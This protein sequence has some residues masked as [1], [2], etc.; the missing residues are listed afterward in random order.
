MLEL[1]GLCKAYDRRVG[2]ALIP[3]YLERIENLNQD[4]ANPENTPKEEDFLKN[5]LDNIQRDLDF[6]EKQVKDDA[7]KIYD[8]WQEIVNLRKKN[9]DGYANTMYDLKVHKGDL[10]DDVLFQLKKKGT[11]DHP[12]PV[13]KRKANV[14]KTP[15]LCRLL[16]DG[17]VVAE[18][19]KVAI[20]WPSYEINILDQFSIH[21]FTLPGNVQL[22]IVINGKTIDVIELEIPGAHVKTLTSASRMVKEY[23]FS[24]I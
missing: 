15:A 2:L 21:M 17:K 23:G 13:L 9:P 12:D 16:I 5:M 14:Q 8:L 11:Q 19:R 18:T 20:D 24:S 1:K 22:E 6:E 4:L 7:Q 3:F 10:G